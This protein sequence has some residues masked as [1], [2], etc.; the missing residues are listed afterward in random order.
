MHKA[1]GKE[2]ME[3]Q[4]LNKCLKNELAAVQMYTQALDTH[5]A[6]HDD[7]AGAVPLREMLMDHQEAAA[8]LRM[9]VQKK[10]G[11]PS[12]DAG[13]GRVNRNR[14]AA[15]PFGDRASLSALKRSEEDAL[16]DY[17]ALAR[18][19]DVGIDVRDVITPIIRREHKHIAQ[20]DQLIERSRS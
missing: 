12:T 4:H 8:R 17:Q 6:A 19:P 10:D 11:L 1:P 20:L 15:K 16:S 9:F 2:R 5:R 13:L 7:D 18:H 3:R 14:G